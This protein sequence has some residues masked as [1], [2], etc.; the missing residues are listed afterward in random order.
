MNARSFLKRALVVSVLPLFFGGFGKV[1]PKVDVE[2]GSTE[3][4]LTG[5]RGRRVS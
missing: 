3:N 4:G 1:G 5:S 2:I